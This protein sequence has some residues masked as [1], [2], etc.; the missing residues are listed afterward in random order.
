MIVF[1]VLWRFWMLHM[2]GLRARFIYLIIYIFVSICVFNKDGG[3]IN[4]H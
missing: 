3:I 2:H 1:V 4:L